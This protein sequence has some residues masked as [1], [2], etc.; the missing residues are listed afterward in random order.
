M[1]QSSI[2][3]YALFGNSVLSVVVATSVA[4]GEGRF[5]IVFGKNQHFL[6]GVQNENKL[7]T[8]QKH[9]SHDI[10]SETCLN[11]LWAVMFW[12]VTVY[13]TLGVTSP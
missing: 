8:V 12:G 3:I 7:P 11:S 4:T 6:P 13:N 1:P 5:Y 2:W 10:P 9:G